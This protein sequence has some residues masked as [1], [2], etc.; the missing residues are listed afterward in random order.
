MS[1][2]DGLVKSAIGAMSGAQGSGQQDQLLQIVGSLLQR[3]GGIGGLMNSFNQAGMGD[4]IKSWV[5][6]GQNSP[7]SANQL[8]QVLGNDQIGQLAQQLGVN[9]QQAGQMLSQ[10][11]P[12]II[13][14]LTPQGQ[15][16]ANNSQGDLM[17]AALGA[18]KGKL[19]G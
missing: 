11:L 6:T 7:I 3:S 10:Y 9:S 13:D 2:L 1:L 17:N 12:Q 18:L 14:H 16:P 19:F 5:S 4:I 15:V 8:S